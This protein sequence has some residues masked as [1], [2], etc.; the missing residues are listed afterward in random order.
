VKGVNEQRERYYYEAGRLFYEHADRLALEPVIWTSQGG[1]LLFL[2]SAFDES[3]E[4]E[5]IYQ[6]KYLENTKL[7]VS[8]KQR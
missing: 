3:P 6:V 7:V 4:I 8:F 5:S 1:N 2:Q